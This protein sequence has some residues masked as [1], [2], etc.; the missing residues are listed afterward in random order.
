MSQAAQ[1]SPHV[2]D[3]LRA[4]IRIA[5]LA[6]AFAAMYL[7]LLPG[8][9]SETDDGFGYAYQVRTVPWDWHVDP[10]HA[11]LIPLG[12]LIS[13]FADPYAALVGLSLVL[14]VMSIALFFWTLLS[15]GY[16]QAWAL[17]GAALLGASY[18]F[19]RYAVEAETYTL[20]TAT[21]LLLLLGTVRRW[22]LPLVIA[23]GALALSNHCRASDWAAVS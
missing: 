8:N 16:S 18:G 13:G 6:A 7:L 10:Q 12:K 2:S 14:G 1:A 3:T 23:L 22:R 5:L 17:I 21:A 20:G 11:L 4:W 15:L 9:R 19:S